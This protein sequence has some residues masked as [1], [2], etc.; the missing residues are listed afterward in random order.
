MASED[1]LNY[2]FQAYPSFELKALDREVADDRALFIENAKKLYRFI[3][4]NRGVSSNPL[5]KEDTI[6][7]F[8]TGSF[9]DDIDISRMD[10]NTRMYFDMYDTIL[11]SFITFGFLLN[12]PG[13]S[14]FDGINNLEVILISPSRNL[15]DGIP[16]YISQHKNTFKD[17]LDLGK[18]TEAE[19]EY[20]KFILYTITDEDIGSKVNI[21]FRWFYMPFINRSDDFKILIPE[22]SEREI[23]LNRKFTKYIEDGKIV[24]KS[25]RDYVVSQI[26][27]Q[28]ATEE[29][30]R[31]VEDFT[32]KFMEFYT[33]FHFKPIIVNNAI[34]I[35]QPIKENYF[36]SN[37]D[38]RL[39]NKSFG[40]NILHYARENF[41]LIHKVSTYWLVNDVNGESR[42]RGC[43]G[44]YINK[45]FLNEENKIDLTKLCSSNV[46]PIRL[47][48]G[49]A[50]KKTRRTSHKEKKERKSQ[51]KKKTKQI[52]KKIAQKITQKKKYLRV[53]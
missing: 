12:Q 20:S 34:F 45:V 1:N 30:V 39:R 47:R 31:F 14:F 8:T 2:P 28:Y 24:S 17:M 13:K 46:P 3:N 40:S 32:N 44:G 49:R 22:I 5:N 51:R 52:T 4:D 29:D 33:S 27:Q 37:I 25:D 26:R 15:K 42:Y 10:S 50:R 36:I 43:R 21:R 53:K 9:Q 35:N 6:V 23:Y 16:Y 48:G 7:V 11:P 38:E 19:D 18:K 41:Y